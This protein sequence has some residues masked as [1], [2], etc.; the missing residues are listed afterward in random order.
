MK[1]EFDGGES[2]ISNYLLSWTGKDGRKAKIF[3]DRDAI[4]KYAKENN[5]EDDDSIL[6]YSIYVNVLDYEYVVRDRDRLKRKIV[7][8]INEL[9]K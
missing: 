4:E 7:L 8:A 2:M 1:A 5:F 3:T 9:E 6:D